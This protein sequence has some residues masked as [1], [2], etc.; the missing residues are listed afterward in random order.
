MKR[1]EQLSKLSEEHQDC[2]LLADKIARIAKEGSDKELSEGIDIVK[3]YNYEALETHLQNEE[4]MIF[5][6]LIQHHREHA[7]LCITLGREHGV[8]RTIVEEISLENAKKDLADFAQLLKA[9]SIMEDKE[10]FPLIESL[11]TEEQL[12]KVLNFAPRFSRYA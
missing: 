2:I 11:F 5:A 7:E 6:P 9:H 8:L 4:Q 3:Q 10:P 1:C 12:N